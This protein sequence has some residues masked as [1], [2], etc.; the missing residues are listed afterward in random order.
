MTVDHRDKRIVT[1]LKQVNI[2]DILEELY[3]DA[4]DRLTHREPL[5][6]RPHV[7]LRD[8]PP[9][10]L[11]HLQPDQMSDIQMTLLRAPFSYMMRQ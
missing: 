1:L 10:L 8:N 2:D 11:Q 3:R 9:C 6:L 4:L 5:T 7:D